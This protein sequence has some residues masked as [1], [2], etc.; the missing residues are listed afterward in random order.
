M[1]LVLMEEGKSNTC[2]DATCKPINDKH[3]VNFIECDNEIPY[4]PLYDHLYTH[5]QNHTRRIDCEYE[6]FQKDIYKP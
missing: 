1:A 4:N 6:D 2:D 3:C 5:K